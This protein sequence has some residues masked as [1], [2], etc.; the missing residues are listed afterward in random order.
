MEWGEDKTQERKITKGKRT[1][2]FNEYVH[3]LACGDDFMGM[4]MSKLIKLY[5]LSIFS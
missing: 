3:Y 2:A 1:L 4:F 5:T